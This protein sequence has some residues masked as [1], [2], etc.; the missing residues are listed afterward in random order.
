MPGMT[1]SAEEI[2]EAALYLADKLLNGPEG[3]FA[4]GITIRLIGVGV[5]RLAQKQ[6][7]QMDLFE[8]AERNESEETGDGSLS[9][10]SDNLQSF[11]KKETENRPL[12]P[13][14]PAAAER[15]AK[16]DAMMDA[17]NGKFGSGTLKKGSK[18]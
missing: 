15:K 16:L 8:W 2:E 13:L 17:V 14:S 10:N 3:L 12:S 5:S 6:M 1:D 4:E 7:H 9:P 18:S 11:L